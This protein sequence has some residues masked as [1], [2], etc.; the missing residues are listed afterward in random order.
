MNK[1]YEHI[2]EMIKS[3]EKG[4][5]V[6]ITE[7]GG[8]VP[9]HVGSKMIVHENGRIFGSVGGGRIE[10]DVMKEAIKILSSGQLAKRSYDLTKDEGMLCGGK[11]EVL[12]EPFGRRESLIIFGAGHICKALA[13]LARQA[14]FH[15]TVV[16]NR[17]EFANR[18]IYPESAADEVMSGQYQEIL[19]QLSFNNQ[20]YIVLVTH[21]HKH[22]EE[23]LEKCIHK[24]FAYLG[25]IGSKRK[26]A[27]ILKRLADQ[28][29]DPKTISK[30]NSPIGLNIGAETPIEIAVSILAE[31]IAVRHKVDVN[32]MS[33]KIS[34]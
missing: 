27:V 24:P 2:N 1:I 17:P 29:V 31:M 3:G 4:V 7:A 30:I 10:K 13:P 9:R 15:V 20:T 32:S 5:I 33:M 11:I 8:S 25:M 16:D 18:D 21:G 23:I 28:S 26:T 12:F 34:N 19:A 14:G 6:T 22:D